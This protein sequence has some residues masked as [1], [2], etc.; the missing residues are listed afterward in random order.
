[1]GENTNQEELR[2]KAINYFNCSDANCSI[3]LE[4]MRILINLIGKEELTSTLIGQLK[5]MYDTVFSQVKANVEFAKT[6]YSGVIVKRYE[7]YWNHIKKEI[8]NKIEALEAQERERF[9][10][11]K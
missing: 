11:G 8:D 9:R 6:I 1:M 2:Q 7:E 10:T 3:L 4:N 5:E